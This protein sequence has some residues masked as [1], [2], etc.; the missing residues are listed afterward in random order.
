MGEYCEEL[1]MLNNEEDPFK[2]NPMTKNDAEENNDLAKNH[3]DENHDL[4]KN[5]AEEKNNVAK[6]HSE[7]NNNLNKNNAEENI[8]LNEWPGWGLPPVANPWAESG[9][10]GGPT[11]TSP[12]PPLCLQT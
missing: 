5:I 3:A 8:D 10:P 11:G 1:D 9:K 6:N 7:E 2:L 12:A 4:A